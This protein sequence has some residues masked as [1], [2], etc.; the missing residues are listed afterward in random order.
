MCLPFPNCKQGSIELVEMLGNDYVMNLSFAPR[1][2]ERDFGVDNACVP[3]I[4]IN[5]ETE[6]R[7]GQQVCADGE[8]NLKV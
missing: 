2:G 8:R 3:A 1:N 6:G 7:D 5:V 4:R